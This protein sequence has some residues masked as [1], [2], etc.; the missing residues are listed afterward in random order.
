MS[1]DRLIQVSTLSASDQVALSS[2]SLGGD[3]RVSLSVL[4]AYVASLLS[5]PSGFETQYE[6]PT[7]TAFEIDV[8]PETA[9]ASVWLLMTPAAVYATGT[10]VLPSSALDKQT[11]SVTSTQAVTALTVEAAD[12]IHGAPTTLAANGYF[13]MRYDGVLRDWFRVG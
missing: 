10:I 12:D 2:G 1:I 6:S 11:V 5:S 7:A 13:S 4:A 9:G 8:D 3:A